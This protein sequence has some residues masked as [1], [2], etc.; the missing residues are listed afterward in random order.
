MELRLLSLNVGR[1]RVIGSRHGEDVL[2]AIAKQPVTAET[3]LVQADGLDGDQQADLSVH[4]GLDKAVYAYPSEHW[5]WWQQDNGLACAPAT[6]G[7]NLTVSGAQEH[8]IAIGDRFEWGQAVLEVSQPRAPCFKLA[9][10]TGRPDVPGLM[11]QSARCGWYLRVLREGRASRNAALRRIHRSEAP[12][13]AEA[14][15][16]LFDTRASRELVQAVFDR[17][18]LA[19]AW[20][21]GL[22]RRLR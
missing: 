1:A 19:Q 21:V 6:F 13:V 22:A 10:H 14:F 16:A 17:P 18:E 9:L 12:T 2:S 7:E 15:T 20:R 8:D 3:I 4:G 11:T 5:P